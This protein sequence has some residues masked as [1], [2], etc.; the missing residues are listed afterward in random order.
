MSASIPYPSQNSEIE[1][2]KRI[3]GKYFSIYEIRLTPSDVSFYVRSAFSDVDQSFDALRRELV[4]QNFVPMLTLE[5]GQYVIHVMK[6]PHTRDTN[7][8]WNI[9]LL[10][11]TL[12]TTAFAGMSLWAGY[13][14]INTL[15]EMLRAD[16][17]IYGVLFFG[18]PLMLI[19]GIHEMGHY[20]AARRHGVKATLPYFI[21]VPP[22]FLFGT[23]GAFISI[24]EPIPDRKALMDI[25]FAGPISGFIVAIP[26]TI[27][28][29]YLSTIFPPAITDGGGLILG[30]SIFYEA[31][32]MLVPF[33]PA[34]LHPMAIAGWVGLF[35]TAINLLPVGQLDG[36]HILYALIGNNARY[37]GYAAIFAMLIMSFLYPGWLFFAF[38][39]VILGLRHPQPLNTVSKIDTKRQIFGILAVLILFTSFVAIPIRDA[40]V[41]FRFSSDVTEKPVSKDGSVSFTMIIKNE[42]EVYTRYTVKLVKV[43]LSNN[44]ATIPDNGFESNISVQFAFTHGQDV[45]LVSNYSVET[46]RIAPGDQ[47]TFDVSLQIAIKNYSGYNFVKAEFVAYPVGIE[48]KDERIVFTISLPG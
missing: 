18:M 35:V 38:L 20:L 45:S 17:V 28:G 30:T 48:N 32:A 23:M 42:G 33:T 44:N 16:V 26:V 39:V 5:S 13:V 43:R 37:F 29:L 22:P 21:P 1:Q 9:L 46:P 24:K 11:G 14:G 31:L 19:L 36:G 6:T 7:V 8:V 10:I 34:G 27:T 40:D 12:C 41:S 2:V 25:G 3:V 4:P 15:E 47:V